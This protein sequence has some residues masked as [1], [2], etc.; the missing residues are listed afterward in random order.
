METGKINS[1]SKLR[2]GKN[3]TKTILTASGLSAVAGVAGAAAVFKF[4]LKKHHKEEDS[5]PQGEYQ[6]DNVAENVTG[7][8]TNQAQ[9]QETAQQTQQPAQHQE[10]VSNENIT[11]PQP[12]DVTNGGQQGG[13]TAQNTPTQ[14]AGSDDVNPDEIAQH[15]ASSNETDPD[16]LDAPDVITVEDMAMA[17]GPDGT[18]VPVAVVRTSDGGQFI[19]ADVDGDGV[20][21]DVF[22][23]DGNYVG[24]VE[25][26]LTAS[27]LQEAADPTGG[28]MAYREDD[29]I[30]EDP[31]QDMI[32][33]NTSHSEQSNTENQIAQNQP[34]EDD[35]PDAEDLLAQ[36][37]SDND[38]EDIDGSDREMVVGPDPEEDDDSDDD[39][40][41]DSDDDDMDTDGEE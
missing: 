31:S 21:T 9:Q 40:S 34:V 18:E 33:T 14:P 16:D 24:E 30:G 11:E 35:A 38:D 5:K 2:G 25:G 27:D 8:E 29:P 39:D 32:A 23:M 28:Y 12:T 6:E 37:M 17:T 1:N 26:N 15:I 7:Q 10:S 4:G 3:N 19:L 20:F 13:G 36:L 41:D 22:D